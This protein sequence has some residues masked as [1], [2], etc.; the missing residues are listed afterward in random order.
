MAH[1][2]FVFGFCVFFLVFV[3]IW[4]NDQ[5]QRNSTNQHEIM[6]YLWAEQLLVLIKLLWKL[7]FFHKLLYV[8]IY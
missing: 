4:K 6:T 7:L 8:F 5:T 3:Q 2:G 1:N